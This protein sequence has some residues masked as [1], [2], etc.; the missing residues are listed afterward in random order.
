MIKAVIRIFIGSIFLFIGIVHFIKTSEMAVYVPVPFGS[1][2][3]VYVIGIITILSAFGVILNK[4]LVA[5][6]ITLAITMSF[7]A[8]LVQIPIS[9]REPEYILKI[10]GLSNL[11][12]LGLATILLLM[13]LYFKRKSK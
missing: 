4:H 12:K 7:S 6:L 3:F 2:Q 5:S 11:V 13:A 1:E 10:I 9:M 8:L